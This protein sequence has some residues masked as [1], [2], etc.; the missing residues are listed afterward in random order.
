MNVPFLDL[1]VQHRVIEDELDRAFHEIIQSTSFVMGSPVEQFEDQFAKYLGARHV[2]GVANGTDALHLSLRAC[3]VGPGDEV[4]TAANTFIATT[5]AISAVG[6]TIVLV[7]MDPDSYTIDPARIEERITPRTRAIIPVH[8]YGQPANM[9]AIMEIANRHNLL[10][11]EDACQAHGARFGGQRV[12]T[13]GTVGCFSCYPGK[14][15][16]AYGDAGIVVTNDDAI[17]DRVRLLANHGSRVKYHH[18]IEGWNSRLDSL[19]AAVLSLKLKYLDAW[20]AERR[21]IAMRYTDALAGS[22]VETPAI[23]NGDHVW[24]LFVVQTADRGDLAD[25]LHQQGVA[26]GIHYPVP[27]HLQPAYRQMGYKPGD[28][29]VTERAATRILSLPM[30]P[31]MPDVHID[32]VVDAIQRANAIFAAA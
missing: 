10:V 8:L 12:G 28:F 9:A 31:G 20:N 22:G 19:Q 16:G 23:V 2:I 26:T 3:G 32:Y 13:I 29:P 17:A 18:E 24:H 30:Y 7:D 15:L 27:L 1:S 6:A 5:E 21:T 25:A 4:I 11:V 14:N